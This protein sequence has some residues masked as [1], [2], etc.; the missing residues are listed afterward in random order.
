MYKLLFILIG[1]AGFF[2][3]RAADEYEAKNFITSTGDT[4]PYRVLYPQKFDSSQKYPLILFLHG[5]GERGNDNAR[6]LT[7]GARMLTNPVNRE[8]Y[9]AV[10]LFPQCPAEEYWCFD[11]KP[12]TYFPDSFP[13]N[14][15][16]PQPLARVTELLHT[17]LT[18][19]YIDTDRIY[20]IGLSM[21]GMGTF[22]MICRN[23]GLFAA[24]V[25]IC[26]IVNPERLKKA[27]I[28]TAVRIFHGDA[29]P[30]VPVEGSRRAYSALKEAGVRVEYEEFPGC[31]HD[32][33]NPAF[34]RPD[35]LS[36]LFRQSK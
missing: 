23:P 17:Y 22:D 21:G 36:W 19:G 25:P 6:Q 18:S 31:G 29:D 34:N 3:V 8:K 10:V 9:P 26:G 33:W 12:A 14:P 7:H 13:E 27:R 35:F 15:P 24:A 5:A 28:R 30:V 1:L 20:I 2:H 4:L 16:L 11:K 32:S